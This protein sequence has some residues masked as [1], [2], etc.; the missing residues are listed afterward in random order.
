MEPLQSLLAESPENPPGAR[1]PA[2]SRDAQ[3]RWLLEFERAQLARHSRQPRQSTPAAPAAD[4]LET[5][6]RTRAASAR[7]TADVRRGE[8]AAREQRFAAPSTL[9]RG[10][11]TTSEVRARSVHNTPAG[12]EARVARDD[13]SKA[14]ALRQPQQPQRPVPVTWPKVHIH[15][16]WNGDSAQLWLRD[17]TLDA[18]ERQ[19]LAARLRAQFRRAGW[20]LE[21]LTVNGENLTEEDLSW[22]SKR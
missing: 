14:A 7:V 21:R 4:A 5:D 19:R 17:A 10:A 2:L 22:P 3:S 11:H 1:G 16:H 13:F 20:R 9:E 6:A 15:A 18:T 8:G 12:G